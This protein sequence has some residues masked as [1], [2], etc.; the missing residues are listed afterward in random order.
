[1]RRKC[2][3]WVIAPTC[4]FSTFSLIALSGSLFLDPSALLTTKNSELYFWNIELIMLPHKISSSAL[5]TVEEYP[6]A[7]WNRVHPAFGPQPFPQPSLRPAFPQDL[8]LPFR[9]FAAPRIGHHLLF[10][11]WFLIFAFLVMTFRHPPSVVKYC[12]RNCDC[13]EVLR[14][15]MNWHSLQF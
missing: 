15:R 6:N 1:M 5:L 12:D 13:D 4:C 2:M 9:L 14:G 10:P 3:A 11:T 7:S 8:L